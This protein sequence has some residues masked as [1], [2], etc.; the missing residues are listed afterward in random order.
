MLSSY[1]DKLLE[2]GAT[3]FTKKYKSFS[4]ELSNPLWMRYSLCYVYTG[5]ANNSFSKC[6][7]SN[8]HKE[9]QAEKKN[10]LSTKF[11]MLHDQLYF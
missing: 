4:K 10:F 2:G 8:L 3:H 5:K 11:Y 6:N 9:F 7:E 1:Q